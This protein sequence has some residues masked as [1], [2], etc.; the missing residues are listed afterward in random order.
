MDYRET[1]VPYEGGQLWSCESGLN[2]H[3]TIL[4]CNGGPG[5]SDYLSPVAD[6]L[7]HYRVIRFEQRGCGRSTADG[8]YDLATTLED[9]HHL[10]QYYHLSQFIIGGHSWGANLA[11]V[12]ALTHP[13]SVEALIYIAGSGIHDNR[14]W[15]EQYH[16]NLES[17]GET[18]P[19]FPYPFNP[20]VNDMGNRTL[21]EFGRDPHLYS[22]IRDLDIPAIFL[23]AKN[24]IRPSWPSQQIANLM[25]KADY[26]TL[27]DSAHYMWLDKADA[28]K[29]ILNDF[30]EQLG[31]FDDC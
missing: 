10:K 27:G 4:L 31:V 13:E 17:K 30:L 21:R 9:I 22:R 24:D 29:N 1:Y 18:Y 7:E 12:Y 5:C 25:S 16:K 11:L 23:M 3:K 6:M 26:V 20:E 8:R 14:H 19:E 2:E 28:M 15:S